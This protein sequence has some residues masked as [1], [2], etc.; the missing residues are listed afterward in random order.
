MNGLELGTK[1]A[2]EWTASERYQSR[3]VA[4]AAPS[5]SARSLAHTTR[6]AIISEPAKVPNLYLGAGGESHLLAGA[7]TA[8]G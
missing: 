8:W 6:S 1:G 3:L 7:D 4:I 2:R 5:E